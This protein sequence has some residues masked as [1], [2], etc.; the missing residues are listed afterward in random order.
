MRAFRAPKKGN[1]GLIR[2]R[3][4]VT[5]IRG[6][7]GCLARHRL[8]GGKWDS[9]KARFAIFFLEILR[10]RVEDFPEFSA[11]NLFS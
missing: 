5:Q 6:C 1:P 4:S 2:A 10:G 9:R 8:K 11:R 3:I 7:G